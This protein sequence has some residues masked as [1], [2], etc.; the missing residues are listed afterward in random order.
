MSTQHTDSTPAEGRVIA[1]I[2]IGTETYEA[3]CASKEEARVWIRDQALRQGRYQGKA[4]ITGGGSRREQPP[5]LRPVE[6]AAPHAAPGAGDVSAVKPH[7]PANGPALPHDKLLKAEEVAGFLRMS[8]S[9]VYRMAA[10]GTLPS[11]QFG[12]SRRFSAAAIEAWLAA[13]RGELVEV[14]DD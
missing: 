14:G 10:E 3:V 1:R 13:Q 2:T 11:V 8:R 5:R 12:F 4:A 6:A 7:A 9:T